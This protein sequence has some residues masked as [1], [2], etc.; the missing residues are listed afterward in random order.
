MV[1]YATLDY[2]NW[3]VMKPIVTGFFWR[4]GLDPALPHFE[5]YWNLLDRESATMVDI[6]HTNCG[7]LGQLLPIGTVDFYANGGIT[8]PGCDRTSANEYNSE[9]CIHISFC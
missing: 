4:T 1:H 8:Q 5:L 9:Y 6:I 3:F 7:G 2:E